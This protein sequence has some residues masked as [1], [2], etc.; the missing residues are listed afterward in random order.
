M[1]CHSC[2]GELEEITDL[3]FTNRGDGVKKLSKEIA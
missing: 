2:G 1:K 3:P